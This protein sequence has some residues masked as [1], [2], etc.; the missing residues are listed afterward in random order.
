MK[1]IKHK[2]MP[3]VSHMTIRV[4]WTATPPEWSGKEDMCGVFDGDYQRLRRFE[5]RLKRLR[6]RGWET[7]LGTMRVIETVVLGNNQE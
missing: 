2:P 5:K 4:F 6:L 3:D 7:T 1:I